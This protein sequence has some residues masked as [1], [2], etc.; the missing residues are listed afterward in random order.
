M[1]P[2]SLYPPSPP[3]VPADLTE[4]TTQYKT[5]IALVLLSLGLFFVVYFGIL[6]AC[7]VFVVWALGSLL[8]APLHGGFAVL[9]V[10]QLAVSVPV[11]LLFIYMVKNLFR[12]GRREK[13]DLVEIFEHEHPRLFDFIY[14]VCD[15][16][17]APYPKR[18]FV[19]FQVNA[20]AFN[21]GNAFWNLFIPSEKNLIIGLGLVNFINLTEFKAVLAHEFGHFSQKT[22]KVGAYVY[23]ALGI[24]NQ[25]VNGRDW[26]DRFI[27]GWCRLDPRVAFP[28]YIVYAILWVLRH[29]LAGLQWVM[30]FFH[31]SLSR[32]MEFNADLVAVSVTGSD[33]PVHLLYRCSFAQRCLVQ[34]MNDIGAAMDHHL[35]TADLFYHQSHAATYFRRRERKPRLGEPPALP[36]DPTQTSTVFTRDDHDQADMWADHPPDYDRERNAKEFYIRTVFDE[37]SPWLLFDDVM[38]L[39]ADVTYKCYRVNYRAKKGLVQAEPEEVQS[40]IDDERAETT[41]DPKYQG[42]YDFRTLILPSLYDLA[43]EA[44]QASWSIAQLT[45]SHATLHDAEAKHRGQLHNKRLE[46]RGF[47]NAVAN[48]WHRPKNNE[49][50]FRG[51]IYDTDEAKRLLRKVDKELER[52]REWLAAHDRRVFLTYFQMALHVSQEIA[53]DLFKRYLF[54]VAL[55][56]IWRTLKEQEAPLQAAIGFLNNAKDN[57]LHPDVFEEL[58]TIFRDAHRALREVLTSAEDMTIPALKNMQAGEPLRPFLLEKR[59]IEGISKYEGAVTSRWM[60]KLLEQVREVQ[61]KLDR[62]HFKSLG[63]ILLLQETIAE[64]CARRWSQLPAVTGPEAKSL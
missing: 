28:A 53:E 25:I 59:L 27:E 23:T 35:Y 63:G 29:V 46:E 33:A 49:L 4:P 50:E 57:R 5:Q 38:Q 47:L 52:D 17:A 43:R 10:I 6:V 39:R 30:F 56:T 24:T 2:D 42:M 58:L 60:N 36:A 16:T 9:A 45:Q 15:D 62:I 1:V 22:M 12:F 7:V 13:D 26:F 51:E 14:R 8:L 19:N 40:F 32:H 44:R 37:R 54:H 20:A 3:N 21:D 64:D 31:Q 48:G 61:S 11:L 18:V 34:S 41:Y 55:Q